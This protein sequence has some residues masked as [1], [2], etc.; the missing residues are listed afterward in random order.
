MEAV[1]WKK[2]GRMDLAGAF[3]R[4]A[5]LALQSMLRWQR[6]GGELWIVKNRGEPAQRL[7]FETYSYHSQYNLLP[8][9]MLATAYAKA[10]EA[11]EERPTPAEAG[12]YVYDLRETFHE[13]AAAA[14]GYYVLIDTAA[15]PH[16]NATGLQRVQRAGVPFS[17]LSDS[18]AGERAYGPVDAA[19]VALSPGVEWMDSEGRWISLASFS[20]GEGPAGASRTVKEVTL[21][22]LD[23][24]PAHTAFEVEY[25]LSG[26]GGRR[27]VE[28][29]TITGEGVELAAHVSGYS[30]RLRLRM[31]ALVSD[32][33]SATQLRLEAGRATIGHA[34]CALRWALLDELAGMKPELVEGATVSHQGRVQ[35]LVVE[36]PA[37]VTTVR[38]RWGLSKQVKGGL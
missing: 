36:A 20:R 34:G 29:Y 9:A 33:A 32:G 12:G 5:H 26:E 18:T 24:S 16:Y 10:D 31:P 25:T 28:A 30:G 37:G 27:L 2:A 7:G 35:P 19:K 17:A 8:M 11:I 38:C 22:V 6:P 4:G 3:K 21:R 14:G 1:R 13:I 23:Q 15:D